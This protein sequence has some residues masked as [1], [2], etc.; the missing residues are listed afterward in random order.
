MK[1]HKTPT[2]KEKNEEAPFIKST[3]SIDQNMKKPNRFQ[4]S[5]V[6]TQFEHISSIQSRPFAIVSILNIYN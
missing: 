3:D 2:E 4:L 5:L 1:K 6:S